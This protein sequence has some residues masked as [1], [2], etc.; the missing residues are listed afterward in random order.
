M[1][2]LFLIRQHAR[3]NR[4][5]NDRIMSAAARL[6]ADE[7]AADQRAFFGSIIETL[8]HV[9]VG[10]SIWL[11]RFAKASGPGS[12]PLRSAASWL[13]RPGALNEVL[14]P[15]LSGLDPLRARIDELIIE[16]TGAL[17][18]TE[19]D[20]VLAYTNTAGRPFRR[21]YGLLILHFF[22][23]QT[24]HR[25]QVSTLLFQNGIDIGVTDMLA[26]I[27]EAPQSDT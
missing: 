6:S 10:D 17:A 11:A 4:W 16:W 15:A 25:G 13:P 2:A 1:D 7:L 8:N 19:L 9:V 12:E 23:H 26:T 20:Q 14:E 24:H 3:Y 27:D 21:P 22:N 5:I 18:G